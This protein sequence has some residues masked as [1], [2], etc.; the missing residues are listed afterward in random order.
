MILVIVML[1]TIMG[2]ASQSATDSAVPTPT[3]LQ[4]FVPTQVFALQVDRFEQVQ[5]ASIPCVPLTSEITAIE[6]VPAPT[7]EDPFSFVLSPGRLTLN[8]RKVGSARLIEAGSFSFR[9]KTLVWRWETFPVK[10]IGGGAKKLRDY[11]MTS[12]FVA[13]L[14][15]GQRVL[16]IP[17]PAE[18]ACAVVADRDDILVGAVSTPTIP[19]RA[20]LRIEWVSGDKWV[21]ESTSPGALAGT[22][23]GSRFGVTVT[24]GLCR[25][26]QNDEKKKELKILKRRIDENKELGAML[27]ERQRALNDAEAVAIA[28]RI[29]ILTAEVKAEQGLDLQSQVRICASDPRSGRVFGIVTTTIGK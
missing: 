24:A 25:V 21:D 10:D 7:A 15:D 8:M 9:G 3:D 20:A 19:N 12:C 18:F 23:R 5:S 1:T 14:S 4:H 28:A 26:Q 27:N 13:L 16:L 6:A 17:P 11:L 22:I 29:E 2:S